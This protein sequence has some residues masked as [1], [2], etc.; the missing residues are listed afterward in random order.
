MASVVFHV[1]G[2]VDDKVVATIYAPET[3]DALTMHLDVVPSMYAI[4]K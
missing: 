2:I 1:Q 4:P 3:P